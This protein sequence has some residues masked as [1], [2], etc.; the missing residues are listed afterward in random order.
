MEPKHI[1]ILGGYGT[2]GLLL[3][4]LLLSETNAHVVLAG[5][6]L[7]KA[8]N[9][10]ACL[11]AQFTGNRVAGVYADAA[12]PLSLRLAFET[13]DIVVVAS[14]T[15]VF[16]RQVARAALEARIDYMDIQ[17][18]TAKMVVLY[19]MAEEIEASGLCFITDG[20]FHPGLP[21]A[22]VHFAASSFDQLE[23]ANVGSVIQIDWASLDLSPST[24]D[25]F[26]GEFLDFQTL[27]FKGGKWQRAGFL[28]MMVPRTMDFGGEFGRQYCMPMFL[29]EM[30]S[31]PECYPSL[32]E[33]G[34]F[35]GGFNW[36]VDWALF[37]VILLVLKLFPEKGLRPMGNLLLWGLRTFSRPPYGTLLKLEAKGSKD[38]T[39]KSLEVTV[40]HADGYLLTAIPVAACLVQYLGGSIRKPG[41]HLQAHIVEPRQFFQDMERMGA[42]VRIVENKKQAV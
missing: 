38:S 13:M 14:S 21:A 26:V 23:S 20:G 41:L 11:N 2:T 10:A 40:A 8:Q 17:Y 7:E 19:E 37:P 27:H 31:L 1:L 24:I 29:E 35:V 28:A 5:R 32:K 6:T 12:D 9:T 25:E 39:P 33:A 18:S 34:F 16:T 30:R 15:V 42:T 3:A 36:F 22:M 4:R